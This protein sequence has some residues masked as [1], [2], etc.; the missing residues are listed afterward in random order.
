MLVHKLDSEAPWALENCPRWAALL[1]HGAV[2][3]LFG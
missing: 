2:G 1:N 3:S